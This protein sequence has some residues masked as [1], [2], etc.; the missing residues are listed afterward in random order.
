MSTNSNPNHIYL[1]GFMGCGKT[2]W[3]KKLAARLEY[4]F[5]DLDT[6]LVERVGKSIAEY[7]A[8]HGE[9]EFRR[10]ES[11]VLK[12]YPYPEKAV[13]STGGGLPCFFDHMD[14]MNTHGQTLYIK[15]SPKTLADRLENA[16]VVRPV[17]Q[18]KKGDELVAFIDGKLAE[19]EGF[20]NQ[21]THILDGLTLNVDDMAALVA[22]S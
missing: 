18:G 14:W 10:L 5:I 12:Q 21:A 20:Y 1:I 2:T 7:F 15:L 16:R 17:L 4:E 9:E 19:R 22:T 6:V 8:E 3:S 11:E 13:I